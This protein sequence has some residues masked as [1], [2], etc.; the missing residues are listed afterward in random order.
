MISKNPLIFMRGG[1]AIVEKKLINLGIFSAPLLPR[2]P[3]SIG[4]PFTRVDQLFIARLA[5]RLGDY[6]LADY[7]FLTDAFPY[8]LR[9]DARTAVIMHD[10]FSGRAVPFET[11]DTPDSVAALT[12]DAEIEMLAKADCI[13]A[14]QSEEAAIVRRHLPYSTIIVV[15]IAGYPVSAAQPGDDNTI[16]FV[17]SNT[18]PNADGLRWFLE[19]CWPL[20]HSRR[21][22][23]RFWVAGTVTQPFGPP[24]PGVTYM[25]LVAELA[26]LY[27]AAGV[28]VSP[29]RAGSGLKVKLIEALEKGK[30]IVASPTTLQGVAD[31]LRDVVRAEETPE[32]FAN[33][34]IALLDDRALRIE[35]ATKGLAA[36]S[37][38]FSP[39][40]AYEPLI[41]Q[42][43]SP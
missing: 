33:A 38:N 42:I 7:C 27:K 9:P 35:M 17:G 18:A 5:P 20:I 29:L 8:A 26:P 11:I 25:G 39:D 16:L 37:R 32:G 19:T 2:A 24:P 40:K 30:A 31:L 4:V 3:Y 21:P 22:N 12:E 41:S 15:P 34:V 14:V 13:I 23:V 36:I 6:L 28:V 1:L 10:L 43:T